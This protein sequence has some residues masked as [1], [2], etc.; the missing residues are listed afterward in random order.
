MTD[1]RFG[2]FLKS[3]G[4]PLILL[5]AG[6]A[7]YYRYRVPHRLDWQK[8]LLETAPGRKI[9][10]DQVLE[11]PVMVHF[12]ASWCGPC[13]RELPALRR[14]ALEHPEIRIALITDDSWDTIRRTGST[15]GMQVY[16]VD[17]LSDCA[18]HTI[19]TTYLLG[20]N[21]GQLDAFQQ[22]ADWDAPEFRQ[23]VIR[24]LGP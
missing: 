2:R 5:V 7:I 16:R 3:F 23:Q 12:Y 11:G 4:L 10:S 21:L 19:P 9:P 8:V 13:M 24:Q 20:K 18:I 15:L 6:A 17:D 1:S 14:F 22:P